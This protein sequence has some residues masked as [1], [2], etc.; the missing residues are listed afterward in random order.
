[1]EINRET[2]IERQ[3]ETET[4]TEIDRLRGRKGEEKCVDSDVGVYRWMHIEGMSDDI[5]NRLREY[6]G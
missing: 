3:I 6:E 2:E 1:M 4:E 5:D